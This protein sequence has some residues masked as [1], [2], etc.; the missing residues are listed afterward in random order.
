M[1]RRSW[2]PN[3]PPRSKRTM[4][5]SQTSTY[6][7]YQKGMQALVER[8]RAV[9]VGTF[10]TA[11]REVLSTELQ[12][13][14]TSLLAQAN[15]LV[16][17]VLQTCEDEPSGLTR[18]PAP[19][20]PFPAD[21]F[22]IA[23]DAATRDDAFSSSCIADIAFMAHVELRQRA[24]RLAG[25]APEAT[26]V[27]VAECDSAL[28]RVTKAL[29]AIDRAIARAE[30]T[31]ACLDYL[32]ELEI[33]LRVR[34]CYAKF[35][36]RVL[37][38]GSEPDTTKCVEACLRRA[39]SEIALVIGEPIYPMLRLDDRSQLRSLQQ[40][41][42]SWIKR[43]AK[44]LR[45]GI[46]VWGDVCAFVAILRQVNR[47]QELAEHDARVVSAAIDSMARLGRLEPFILVELR[48]LIGRD[49]AVDQLLTSGADSAEQ[50]GP[51][52]GHL[53]RDMGQRTTSSRP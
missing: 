21:D 3:N 29:C 42:L 47:R 48:T 19:S 25:V 45:D 41:I 11:P 15:Q 31:P 14:T 51:V 37:G 10:E 34:R 53:A 6:H 9:D 30:G 39:G 32:S 5:A 52:L 35:R 43:P 28:R 50:W 22:E 27:L 33:S 2:G 20:P 12:P 49:E 46:H 8:V 26:N 17:G 23:I 16:R 18:G 38:D 1:C 7:H 24:E 13:Q 4:G 44:D 40:R 36:V